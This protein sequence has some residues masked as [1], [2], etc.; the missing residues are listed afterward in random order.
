VPGSGWNPRAWSRRRQIV[1]G[2]VGVFVILIVIGAAA[3]NPKKAAPTQSASQ[4]AG[5]NRAAQAV[6]RR[7]L[8]DIAY[9]REVFHGYALEFTRGLKNTDH[10]LRAAKTL[11]VDGTHNT[12]TLSDRSASG[13]TFTVRGAGT[14]LTD[15]CK[16]TGPG[17]RN[18]MWA[19]PATLVL[20]AIK[21]LTPAQKS[22]VQSILVKSLRHYEFL[23]ALGLHV[24]GTTQYPNGFAGL[25]A[26]AV[27]GSPAV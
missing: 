4:V 10:S 3:G 26:L 2:V 23:F 14:S 19:G 8:K 15:T 5:E 9:D 6:L 1:A 18:G 16:P 13:T 25:D 22:A 17:C 11:Y 7:A 24:L 21:K 27:K 12:F 20:P